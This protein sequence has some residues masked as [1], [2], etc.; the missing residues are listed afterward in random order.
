MNCIE[1]MFIVFVFLVVNEGKNS[2]LGF[3]VG[4]VL[5]GFLF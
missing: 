5:V 4:I 1:I 3:E 2:F